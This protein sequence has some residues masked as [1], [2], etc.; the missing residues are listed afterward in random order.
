MAE[1]TLL[2]RIQ[3]QQASQID[4]RE[5]LRMVAE[6]LLEVNRRLDQIERETGYAKPK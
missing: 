4:V 6:A 1:W 5:W 2:E 3:T